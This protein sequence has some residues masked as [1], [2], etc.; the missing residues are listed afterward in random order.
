MRLQVQVMPL[1]T[2]SMAVMLTI[3]LLQVR[4]TTSYSVALVMIRSRVRQ[5][6]IP[7][8]SVL[9]VVISPT[10]HMTTS[11]VAVVILLLITQEI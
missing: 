6:T 10:A 5:V 2:S 3:R 8:S 11:T 4:A 1:I 7:S 9:I